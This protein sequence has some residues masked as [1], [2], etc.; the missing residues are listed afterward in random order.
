MNTRSIVGVVLFAVSC[1]GQK[2]TGSAEPPMAL[3]S[4][5]T[6]WFRTLK[7]TRRKGGKSSASSTVV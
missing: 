5:D 7:T 1:M 3:D 6:M 4:K 2:S